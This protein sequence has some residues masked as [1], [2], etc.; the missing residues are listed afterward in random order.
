MTR[1]LGCRIETLSTSGHRVFPRGQKLYEQAKA[2]STKHQCYHQKSIGADGVTSS[3][4]RLKR[5]SGENPELSRSGKQERTSS[6]C[7]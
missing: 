1:P 5:E 2:C 7:H 3:C 4:R 6:N